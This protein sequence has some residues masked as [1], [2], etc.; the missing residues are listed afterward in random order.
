MANGKLPFHKD[1]RS[2]L[3]VFAAGVGALF[4]W[5]SET[6]RWPISIDWIGP[7][8]LALNVAVFIT[9]NVVLGQRSAKGEQRRSEAS[10]SKGGTQ[11]TGLDSPKLVRDFQYAIVSLLCGTSVV[12]VLEALRKA[13]FALIAEAWTVPTGFM[14][15]GLS[16]LAI[17]YLRRTGRLL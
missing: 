12:A 16:H 9:V 8:W 17:G 1:I 6:R 7:I 3:F 15:M 10:F 14:A 13:G 11:S 4:I 2:A 5:L